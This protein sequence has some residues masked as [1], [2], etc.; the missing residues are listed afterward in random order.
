MK[1]KKLLFIFL[2]FLTFYSCLEP[3]DATVGDKANSLLVV[4]GLISNEEI[5]Y[6]V[7]LTRTVS[8]IDQG[9]IP[10]TGATVTIEDHLGLKTVLTETED[11]IYETDPDEFVGMP[12]NE[13][14]LSIKTKEGKRYQ[15]ELC[16]MPQPSEIDEVYFAPGNETESI[17]TSGFNGV[18]MY[19]SGHVNSDDVEYLRWSFNEDWKFQVPF[20]PDEI[21]APC[22]EMV[23]V[24]QKKYCW[25]SSIS[26]EILLQ[27]FNSQTERKV[28][29]KELYF[30]NTELTDKLLIRYSSLIKQYSISREEYDFW[31][32]ME[33]ANPDVGDIF[34]EQPFAVTG[35][36]KR[37]DNPDEKVLGYFQVAGCATKRIYINFGEVH[38]LKLPMF[39]SYARCSYDSLMLDKLNAGSDPENPAYECI[40]DIYDEFVL[41]G[42]YGYDYAFPILAGGFSEKVIGLAL[43]TPKCTDC[44]LAGDLNPP[45]FWSETE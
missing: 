28:Q 10:V 31:R 6:T 27:S 13:Y 36:I 41:S 18:G 2:V 5:P 16:K 32:K 9:I 12:G 35:N 37:I 14:R 43:T 39:N 44:T 42:K 3:F 24:I 40:Y 20:G 38:E 34:G 19:I 7:R 22:D 26:N 8:N 29:D 21:P 4:D 25:K 45:D 1:L 11:G 33:M 23:P 15:S 30:I 17:E